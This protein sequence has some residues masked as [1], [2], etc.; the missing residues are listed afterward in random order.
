[1]FHWLTLP[2]GV[3][4][5]AWFVWLVVVIGFVVLGVKAVKAWGRQ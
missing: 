2:A 1:M 5:L 4:Y 3:V